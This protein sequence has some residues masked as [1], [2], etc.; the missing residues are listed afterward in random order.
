MTIIWLKGGC[1][2]M[3]VEIIKTILTRKI[4]ILDKVSDEK[5]NE[6]MSVINLEPIITEISNK[7]S[8]S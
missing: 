1:T 2:T 7:N 5:I 8:I 6:F 3:T 4:N